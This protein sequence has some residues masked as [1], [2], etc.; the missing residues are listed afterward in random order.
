MK[1]KF[2]GFQILEKDAE[3]GQIF[4][5]P[6]TAEDVAVQLREMGYIA[7]KPQKWIAQPT[8]NLREIMDK[9]G[10]GG[11]VVTIRKGS[12]PGLSEDPC[13]KMAEATDGIISREHEELLKRVSDPRAKALG[14][15]ALTKAVRAGG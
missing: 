14:R 12:T 10:E 6:A 7:F 5:Y 11:P 8:L 15:A 3:R 1:G 4:P 9:L 13:L 2:V